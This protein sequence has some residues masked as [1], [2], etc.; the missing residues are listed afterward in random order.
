MRV[1]NDPYSLL[2]L[3]SE[4][5]EGLDEKATKKT[6]NAAYISKVRLLH[7]D[8]TGVDTPQ[9]HEQLAELL[10]A[11]DQLVSD[12]L[13]LNRDVLLGGH[14]RSKFGGSLDDELLETL[15]S[16][17]EGLDGSIR[18]SVGHSFQ[19]LIDQANGDPNHPDELI[20]EGNPY[21]R[22][23]LSRIGEVIREGAERRKDRDH[24]ANTSRKNAEDFEPTVNIS[25]SAKAKLAAARAQLASAVSQ[26]STP[27][28][29]P[30]LRSKREK[31]LL[32]RISDTENMDF[33]ALNELIEMTDFNSAHGSKLL[34]SPKLGE[35]FHLW[36]AIQVIPPDIKSP[37]GWTQDP[38]PEKSAA[39]AIARKSDPSARYG[40]KTIEELIR[41]HLA[42]PEYVYTGKP[43][44]SR[45]VAEKIRAEIIN[46]T[47]FNTTSGVKV[48]RALIESGSLSS[49]NTGLEAVEKIIA[50]CDN[51]S[52][53]PQEHSALQLLGKAGLIDTNGKVMPARDRGSSSTQTNVSFPELS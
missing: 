40:L 42:D 17:L 2:G 43:S 32:G 5:L 1:T 9:V 30:T 11:R 26:K 46:K 45:E 44:Y 4:D 16:F 22:D 48:L 8:V 39:L 12:P 38:D 36:L 37:Q 29:L 23:T 35:P 15:N 49:G 41:T 13:G 28:N 47:D 31:E 18:E 10:A 53:K 33:E 25:S 52:G 3:K 21:T 34:T 50:K 7:P 27:V 20:R 19:V 51:P 14:Y 6:I 24:I